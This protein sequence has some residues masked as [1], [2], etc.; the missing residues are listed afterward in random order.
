MKKVLIGLVMVGLLF[1]FTTSA[2]AVEISED[3]PSPEITL[4][5]RGTIVS[6]NIASDMVKQSIQT[7]P[8]NA[9]GFLVQAF[10]WGSELLQKMLEYSDGY[11]EIESLNEA[12]VGAQITFWD[13]EN[14]PV[15]LVLGYT[16]LVDSSEIEGGHWTVGAKLDEI[17]LVGQMT[18]IFDW[19]RPQ[20]LIALFENYQP[21][22]RLAFSYD[23]RQKE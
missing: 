7:N 13:I 20:L 8:V 9:P 17:P 21:A 5:A 10:N 16:F 19:V 11:I 6:M 3:L 1:C 18:D 12:C 23:W 2:I 14:T 15:E 22:Y 4:P